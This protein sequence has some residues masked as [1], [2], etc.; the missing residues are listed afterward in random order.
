VL[1]EKEG[2]MKRYKKSGWVA[3]MS[4]SLLVLS[5]GCQDAPKPEAKTVPPAK[6]SIGREYGE[7][8]HGA[9]T[10]AQEA[11]KTVEESSKKALG[12]MDPAR[13]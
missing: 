2:I 10:Q 6:P 5:V 4:G 9:I 11:R 8:L 7:T 13:E 12:P 1:R 3:L